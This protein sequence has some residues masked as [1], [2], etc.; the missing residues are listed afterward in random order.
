MFLSRVVLAAV[1]QDACE[2]VE[3]NLRGRNN[4][5]QA[6]GVEAGV[7]DAVSLD[8]GVVIVGVGCGAELHPAINN[9]TIASLSISD[10]TVTLLKLMYY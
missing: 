10:F 7:G 5:A 3:G 8:T 6:S 9:A 2:P 4:G 1:G